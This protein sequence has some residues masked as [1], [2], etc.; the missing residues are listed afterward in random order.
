MNNYSFFALC[1]FLCFGLQPQLKARSSEH[2]DL[3][4]GY[5]FR[6]EL[7]EKETR[8]RF[9]LQYPDGRE[10]LI[11][12]PPAK[13]YLNDRLKPVRFG[14]ISYGKIAD[15][16]FTL[17]V[18]GDGSWW[19]IRWDMEKRQRYPVVEFPDQHFGMAGWKL[20]DGGSTK[21]ILPPDF[22]QETLTVDDN[23]ILYK[24]GKPWR[25]AGYRVFGENWSKMYMQ[26]D[27]GGEIVCND[28]PIGFPFDDSI[29][30][31]FDF[32]IVNADGTRRPWFQEPTLPDPTDA[33][34]VG[35][36]N[37][38]TS[39]ETPTHSDVSKATVGVVNKIGEQT[40]L[41]RSWVT[42]T[43]VGIASLLATVLGW[44][45]FRSKGSKS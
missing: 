44:R 35:G 3:P 21:V 4:A 1:G 45:F 34:R 13:H 11:W 14:V 25:G 5:G 39:L 12:N 18:T 7:N 28:T 40:T 10:D 8:A 17:A 6:I 24:D 2:L 37:R 19:W 43:Y 41:Q 9:I 29:T 22:K 38:N 15:Q 33:K 16:T 26:L 27:L 23:G 32:Y 20:L 36:T 42:W 30:E 31:G